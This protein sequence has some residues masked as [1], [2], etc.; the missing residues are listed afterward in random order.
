MWD[1]VN[2]QPHTQHTTSPVPFILVSDI[3]CRLDRK[4]SLQ[5]VAPTI[6]ELMNIDKP[7]VM[8]GESLVLLEDDKK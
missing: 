2:N 7:S 4:E 8:T 1:E 5:D 6:L 3:K